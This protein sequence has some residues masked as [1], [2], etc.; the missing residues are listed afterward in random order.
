MPKIIEHLEFLVGSSQDAP[1]GDKHLVGE[2]E[3]YVAISC[4][5]YQYSR[6]RSHYHESFRDFARGILSLI[7]DRFFNVCQRRPGRGSQCV[8]I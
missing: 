6:R 3:T 4:C 1:D 5:L 7:F 8:R 2:W